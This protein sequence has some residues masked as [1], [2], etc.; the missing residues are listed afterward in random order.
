MK[1]KLIAEPFEKIDFKK[2]EKRYSQLKSLPVFAKL[3]KE[4]INIEDQVTKNPKMFLCFLKIITEIIK[5]SYKNNGASY[6]KQEM[7]HLSKLI[8]NLNTIETA[9]LKQLYKKAIQTALNT[10]VHEKDGT[11]LAFAF[12]NFDYLGK[13]PKD[14]IITLLKWGADATIPNADGNTVLHSASDQLKDYLK[15]FN[16]IMSFPEQYQEFEKVLE[17]LINSQNNEGQTPIFTVKTTT[18][19]EKLLKHPKINLSIL[20]SQKNALKYFIEKTEKDKNGYYPFA[21]INELI[22]N[23]MQLF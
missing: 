9:G 19:C 13:D 18:A 14:I 8:K 12:L 1:H 3:F 20:V 15:P 17:I 7:P 21:K 6:L 5:Y 2:A 4:V 11:I 16:I 23:S 10:L 22:K